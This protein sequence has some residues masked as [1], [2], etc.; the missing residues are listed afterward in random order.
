M[1][2]L[3][4][5]HKNVTNIFTSGVRNERKPTLPKWKTIEYFMPNRSKW[6]APWTLCHQTLQELCYGPCWYFVWVHKFWKVL[7]SNGLRHG[8]IFMLFD[9]SCFRNVHP[10]ICVFFY[11]FVNTWHLLFP[12]LANQLAWQTT[13]TSANT[14]TRRWFI[15]P[16]IGFSSPPKTIHFERFGQLP[17]QWLGLCI[18]GLTISTIREHHHKGGR[19]PM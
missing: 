15:Y 18:V 9:L 1:H 10:G 7:Q 2:T 11:H 12:T 19:W 4:S 13:S 14:V 6:C 3:I 16:S 17:P 8:I 5:S